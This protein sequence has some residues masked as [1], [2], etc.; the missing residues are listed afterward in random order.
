MLGLQFFSLLIS[1]SSLH[2]FPKPSAINHAINHCHLQPSAVK[3]LEQRIP[4]SVFLMFYHVFFFFKRPCLNV[5]FLFF[6]FFLSRV[7]SLFTIGNR[8]WWMLAT[9]LQG[10]GRVPVHVGCL[11]LYDVIIVIK[12][13]ANLWSVYFMG[14]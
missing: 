1:V 7:N 6:C 14:T 5:F 11:F 3:R 10:N 2:F 8:Y 4:D 12:L 9:M 13:R